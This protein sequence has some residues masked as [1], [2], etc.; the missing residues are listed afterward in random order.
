MSKPDK[1]QPPTSNK[2]DDFPTVG[3]L[4]PSRY[5][6]ADDLRGRDV[7]VTIAAIAPRDEL[8]RTDGSKDYKPVVTLSG[9]KKQ[10]VLNVTN[11]NVIAKLYGTRD[12]RQWIGKAIT[13]YPTQ[14]MSFGEMVPAIRVR[15][16]LP[17]P[18]EGT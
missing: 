10:W 18:K 11:A 13:I 17:R 2:L 3:L 12:A 9:A 5:L 6:S 15:P 7:T 8:K 1:V 16:T 14:V 4:F